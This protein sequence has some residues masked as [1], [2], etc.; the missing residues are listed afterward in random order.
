M[1]FLREIKIHSKASFGEEVKLSTHVVSFCG[2]LK[3][4]S[5]VI[6]ILTGKI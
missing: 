1:D 2:M 4:P 3:V 6:G 5:H